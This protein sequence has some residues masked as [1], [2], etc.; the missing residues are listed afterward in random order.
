MFRKC[1]FQFPKIDTAFEILSYFLDVD[2][3]DKNGT[4]LN[5]FEQE[6]SQMPLRTMKL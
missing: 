2:K 1:R 4:F 6:D 5:V 3:A